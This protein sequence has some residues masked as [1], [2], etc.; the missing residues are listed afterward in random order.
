MSALITLLIFYFDVLI[1]K[2]L[3]WTINPN[4]E[5]TELNS[6]SELN[7]NVNFLWSANSTEEFCLTAKLCCKPVLSRTDEM[8]HQNII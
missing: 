4:P 3:N 6:A 7:P 1:V 2:N 5:W 8:E